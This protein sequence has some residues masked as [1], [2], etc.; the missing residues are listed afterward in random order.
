VGTAFFKTCPPVVFHFRPPYPSWNHGKK[1][2]IE[3]VFTL[4]K[5]N[6]L[7]LNYPALN[8]TLKEII[9]MPLEVDPRT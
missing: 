2:K 5:A 8:Q 4:G 1:K 3:V 7:G 6:N 9:L